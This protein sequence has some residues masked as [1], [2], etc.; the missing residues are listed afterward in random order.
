MKKIRIFAFIAAAVLSAGM[1]SGCGGES[2]GAGKIRTVP[3]MGAGVLP[4][5][6]EP[7]PS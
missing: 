7:I 6:R 4:R 1:L 2:T 3:L 5:R